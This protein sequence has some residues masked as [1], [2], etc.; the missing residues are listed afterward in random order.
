MRLHRTGLLPFNTLSEGLS[1]L[2]L[3]GSRKKMFDVPPLEQAV[4]AGK[5]LKAEA[6]A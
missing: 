6:D 1:P 4:K 3:L 5:R 2:T